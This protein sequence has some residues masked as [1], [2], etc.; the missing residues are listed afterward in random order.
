M[1]VSLPIKNGG[2]ETCYGIHTHKV[3]V[4]DDECM[5]VWLSALPGTWERRTCHCIAPGNESFSNKLFQL[6]FPRDPHCQ[7]RQTWRWRRATDAALGLGSMR[8]RSEDQVSYPVCE[9]WQ[10]WRYWGHFHMTH[11]P[12]IYSWLIYSQHNRWNSSPNEAK[13]ILPITT[14]VPSIPPDGFE[15]FP[16]TLTKGCVYFDI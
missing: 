2:R 8:E 11:P 3:Q 1:K 14:S 5:R 4:L 16:N 10:L 6:T 12:A 7:M 13:R 15:L 9:T